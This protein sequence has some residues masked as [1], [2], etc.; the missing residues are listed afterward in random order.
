MI[1]TKITTIKNDSEIE[2]FE[3]ANNHTITSMEFETFSFIRYCLPEFLKTENDYLP[4]VVNLLT[5]RNLY[6]MLPLKL[7]NY[8]DVNG[9]CDGAFG[10]L[11]SPEINLFIDEIKKIKYKNKKLKNF[12]S[13]KYDEPRLIK[14][15]HKLIDEQ[16]ILNK[17]INNMS[18][19]QNGCIMICSL[20][21]I[22][23]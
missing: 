1:Q 16:K 4:I 20:N 12:I 14:K 18:K 21:K 8:L 22:N 19:T 17:L 2:E 5:K 23:N 15:F 6:G 10:F 3:Q 11:Y 9:Y 7:K 13:K